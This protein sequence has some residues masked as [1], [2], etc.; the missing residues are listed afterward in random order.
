MEET[1]KDHW[2]AVSYIVLIAVF[3]IGFIYAAYVGSRNASD[4]RLENTGAHLKPIISI[5]AKPLACSPD[6]VEK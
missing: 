4:R 3:V 6:Q 2:L 1:H 5:G